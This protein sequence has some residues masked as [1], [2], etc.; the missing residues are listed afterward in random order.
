MDFCEIEV[1]L[2]YIV[3]NQLGLEK[4]PVSKDLNKQINKMQNG[5]KHR[6]ISQPRGKS[7]TS[8]GESTLVRRQQQTWRR[9]NN[10]GCWQ[11]HG[12]TRFDRQPG[13]ELHS[14]REGK[15]HSRWQSLAEIPYTCVFRPPI[16]RHSTQPHGCGHIPQTTQEQHQEDFPTLIRT[17]RWFN[18][19]WHREYQKMDRKKK[20]HSAKPEQK[21]KA[22]TYC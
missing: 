8:H 10:H 1:N 2:I 11:D 6:N 14:L 4:D 9:I 18:K 22:T 19:N 21:S 17:M 16:F 3:Q 7:A 15:T 20:R 12:I 5:H 13:Q